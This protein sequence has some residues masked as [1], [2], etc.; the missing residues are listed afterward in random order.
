MRKYLL[1]SAWVSHGILTG[2][3]PKDFDGYADLQLKKS[4]TPTSA[5][6]RKWRGAFHISE[7]T[8]WRW[9]GPCGMETARGAEFLARGEL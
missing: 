3:F 2:V 6:E 8:T 9:R 5:P 7:D 4:P 1:W